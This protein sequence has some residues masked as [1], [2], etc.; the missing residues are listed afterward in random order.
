[1]RLGELEAGFAKVDRPKNEPDVDPEARAR[2]AALGYVG[3][4]VATAPPDASRTGL[5]DPKD[6]IRVFNLISKA[7]DISK[8]EKRFDEVVGMLREVVGDDPKVIDAWF[9]LGNV[10]ARA[11]Q[12]EKAIEY[13]KRVLQLKPDD[14]M[15]V[16][17]MANAYRQIGKDEEA[18]VGYNRFLE[19]DPKSSQIRYEVAQILIDHG[20]LDEAATRLTEALQLDPKM[21][22]ARNALGVVALRKGDLNLAG[23]QIRQAIAQRADVRLAHF[24]LALIA[25]ERRDAQTALQEY[26]KEIE[27]HPSSYRAMFN[28][29]RLYGQLGQREAQ[30]ASYRDAIAANPMFSEGHLYLAKLLLDLNRDL[31]EAVRLAARG[32]ELKPNGEYAPLGHYVL[33]DIYNRQGRHADSAREAERGRMLEARV[34][35]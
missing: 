35:R 19:L 23:Q 16:V 9:M 27:L 5:A 24:N 21:A 3:S 4:F 34:S 6:K 31:P 7:R 25:E 33:A 26:R 12:Q 1:M 20:R 11:N 14:E 2:L 18:L 30:L 28:L 13:F 32:I 22:A 29:G 15:A 17:N 8:D 10:H